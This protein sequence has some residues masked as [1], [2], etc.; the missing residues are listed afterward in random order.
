MYTNLF[1]YPLLLYP[2]HYSFN[3]LFPCVVDLVTSILG[4]RY[5]FSRYQ[6]VS[7]HFLGP[8]IQFSVSYSHCS[9]SICII[10]LAPVPYF[11][12]F[13]FLMLFQFGPY[14]MLGFVILLLEF[15][16]SSADF[17]FIWPLLLLVILPDWFFAFIF[18]VL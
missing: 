8:L 5:S 6:T 17:M 11:Y 18:I 7:V 9:P 10:V 2:F 14:I 1:F 4:F 3:Y 13:I 16:R 12:S 15:H